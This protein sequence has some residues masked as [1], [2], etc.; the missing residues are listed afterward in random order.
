MY[1]GTAYLESLVLQHTLDGGVLAVGRNLGLEDHAEGAVPYNLTLG[2]LHLA[3][4]SRNTILD[5]FAYNL[6]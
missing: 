5:L 6:C 1:D 3:G 2:I 4:L